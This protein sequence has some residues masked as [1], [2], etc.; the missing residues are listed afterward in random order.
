MSFNENQAKMKE[1]SDWVRTTYRP[2][3]NLKS[4][5][6]LLAGVVRCS[7]CGRTMRVLYKDGRFQY[8]CVRTMNESVGGFCQ[9]LSGK[10]IDQAVV[11]EFLNALS[12]AN[13]DAL[14]ASMSQATKNQQDRIKQLQDEVTRLEYA[15]SKLERQYENVDP[16]NRLI[17]STLEERWERALQD[18]AIDGDV[19][20]KERNE[21][22]TKVH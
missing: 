5:K 17:A 13:V 10:V 19:C 15:A 3:K 9:Y 22:G 1:N 11:S 8:S 6:A 21:A 16:T 2:S 20:I 12:T 4:G 7:K 18:L 14:T